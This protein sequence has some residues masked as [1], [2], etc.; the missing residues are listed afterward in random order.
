MDPSPI[1]RWLADTEQRIAENERH[2]SAQL[3]I[4]AGLEN[5]GR[6]NSETAETAREILQ[7]MQRALRARLR[8]RRLLHVQLRRAVLNPPAA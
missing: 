6:G 1:E 4:I 2:I 5:A 7:S 8:A 3:E